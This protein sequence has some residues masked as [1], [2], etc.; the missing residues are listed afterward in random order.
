MWILLCLCYVKQRL[1]PG[2]LNDAR[3]G[4]RSTQILYFPDKLA[5][6][7]LESLFFGIVDFPYYLLITLF[8]LD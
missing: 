6:G 2:R 5:P 8:L 7:D 4:A 3:F 1:D